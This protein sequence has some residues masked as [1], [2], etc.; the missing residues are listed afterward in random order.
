MADK[1]LYIPNN[2]TQNYSYCRL[3]FMVKH[4]DTQLNQPTNQNLIKVPK[5]VKQ[6]NK[7]CYYNT[8]GTSV[9]NG[10]MS[11]PSLSRNIPIK[12]S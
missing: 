12:V 6:M 10:Q 7:D 9:I 1:V 8:L 3:Q 2:Y 5:V 4:L 11:P